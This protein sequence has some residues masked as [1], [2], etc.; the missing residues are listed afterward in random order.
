MHPSSTVSLEMV[1]KAVRDAIERLFGPNP[2]IRVEAPDT[3]LSNDNNGEAHFASSS[4]ATPQQAFPMSALGLTFAYKESGVPLSLAA[5]TLTTTKKRV[6]TKSPID[7]QASLSAIAP[8][9]VDEHGIEDTLKRTYPVW[10]TQDMDAL[11]DSLFKMTCRNVPNKIRNARTKAT[12]NTKDSQLEIFDAFHKALLYHYMRF[13]FSQ[14]IFDLPSSMLTAE[15]VDRLYTIGYIANK[16]DFVTGRNMLAHGALQRMH[17]RTDQ[18]MSDGKV[19][20][21]RRRWALP[22]NSK[23]P[24]QYQI[25]NFSLMMECR[26]FKCPDKSERGCKSSNQFQLPGALRPKVTFK[27]IEHHEDTYGLFGLK[28]EGYS[29]EAVEELIRSHDPTYVLF[30]DF[31]YPTKTRVRAPLSALLD[32]WRG[33]KDSAAPVDARIAEMTVAT[34]DVLWKVPAG[35]GFV[36]SIPDISDIALPPSA[37]PPAPLQSGKTSKGKKRVSPSEDASDGPHRRTRA[38]LMEP[39]SSSDPT[40][41]RLQH[42]R[43]PKLNPTP[44]EKPTIGTK[45]QGKK[46]AREEDAESNV[47]GE[48]GSS[49]TK[50]HRGTSGSIGFSPGPSTSHSLVDAGQIATLDCDS[51]P[52]PLLRYGLRFIDYEENAFAEIP[53]IGIRR[54][55]GITFPRVGEDNTGPSSASQ[56]VLTRTELERDMGSVYLCDGMMTI[57]RGD[58]GNHNSRVAS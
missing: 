57:K 43:L 10:P 39:K 12:A 41:P 20:E 56:Q 24:T 33:G 29:D 22:A 55:H 21:P 26:R 5:E 7:T 27:W 3:K 30:S 46:R 58:I 35:S 32:A 49:P 15:D 17:R 51:I 52:L 40:K 44:K 2:R 11:L 53:V 13:L 36:L 42:R 18:L 34:V 54:G 16:V 28:K 14:G 19:L 6:D 23:P 47:E 38:R 45:A 37:L 25:I 9:P 31:Q 4:K 48:D 1:W 8:G 50:R